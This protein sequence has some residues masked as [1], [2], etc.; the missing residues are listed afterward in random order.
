MNII[1]DDDWGSITKKKR[2]SSDADEEDFY[3]D[4]IEGEG[5]EDVELHHLP[6][7]MMVSI[8]RKDNKEKSNNIGAWTSYDGLSPEE[9]DETP[10]QLQLTGRTRALLNLPTEAEEQSFSLNN[11]HPELKSQ[12]SHQ[13]DQDSPNSVPEQP[14][15]L[16]ETEI[17]FSDTHGSGSDTSHLVVRDRETGQIVGDLA[18]IAESEKA[19]HD[20]KIKQDRILNQGETQRRLAELEKEAEI[21]AREMTFSRDESDEEMNEQLKSKLHWDDPFYEMMKAKEDKRRRKEARRRGQKE[22]AVMNDPSQRIG[23]INRFGIKPGHLWDG[24]ERG[25]GFEERYF[26]RINEMQVEKNEAYLWSV[27]NY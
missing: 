21:K 16:S 22:V 23:P 3:L 19:K 20:R 14:R 17:T 4:G 25:N 11:P 6:E 9:G 12:H 2:H 18:S 24:K 1:D 15:Y 7:E 13:V 27:Q 8:L 26:R 5:P 10:E